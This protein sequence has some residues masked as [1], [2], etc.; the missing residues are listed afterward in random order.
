M[1]HRTALTLGTGILPLLAAAC[2][3]LSEERRALGNASSWHHGVGSIPDSVRLYMAA[4]RWATDRIEDALLGRL[5]GPDWF[6]TT[7]A[8]YWLSDS[9]R[10]KYLRTLRRFAGHPDDD[11]ATVAIYGL[12]RYSGDR[13]VRERLLELD[14]TASRIVR[15][16]MASML[17]L[18]NDSSARGLLGAISLRDLA[19]Y[20]IEI[21]EKT[22]S[23][24]P[25][26]AGNFRWPCLPEVPAPWTGQCQR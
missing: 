5:R 15:N 7:F 12:V 26:P 20:T 22:L 4:N 3:L 9:G 8:V 17:A 24:P 2:A 16:N 18:A 6:D 13:A 1:R 25:R 21:I 23:A 10:R 14:R 11:V 19:P